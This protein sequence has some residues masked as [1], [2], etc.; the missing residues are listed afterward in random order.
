MMNN[1]DRTAAAKSLYEAAGTPYRPDTQDNLL[2]DERGKAED[3]LGKIRH[4]YA[5]G[6]ST[7]PQVTHYLRKR[8]IGPVTAAKY[9]AYIPKGGLAKVLSPEEI[10]LS[11]LQYR[12]GKLVL[13][14]LRGDRPV[15]YCTRGIHEKRFL[16]AKTGI[17]E[18]PIWNVD[19]L[20]SGK[21]VVCAEGLFDCLSLIELGYAVAGEITCNRFLYTSTFP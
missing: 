4:Q 17:L 16:K 8:K 7:P 19:A 11:G 20:Y 3:A 6:K 10:E 18:H 14:Y 1:G 5:I 21:Q 12:E 13:W 9:L 15:Y 2:L